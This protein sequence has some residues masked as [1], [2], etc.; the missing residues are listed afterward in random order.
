MLVI[1]LTVQIVDDETGKVFKEDQGQITFKES[2][3]VLSQWVMETAISLKV[4]AIFEK[5]G[6]E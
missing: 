6:E 2:V 5:K 1:R 3:S 4:K